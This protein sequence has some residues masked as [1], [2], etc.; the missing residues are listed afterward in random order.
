[1]H[2]LVRSLLAHRVVQLVM[3]ECGWPEEKAL[4]EF[5]L[6]R[7]ARCFADD[8]FGLYGQSAWHIFGLWRD[9]MKYYGKL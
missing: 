6:S 3:Q 4:D 7:T 2:S 8:K 5:Y 1:M 9:E